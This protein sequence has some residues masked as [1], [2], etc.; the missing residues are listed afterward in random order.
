VNNAAAVGAMRDARRLWSPSGNGSKI[1]LPS[2]LDSRGAVYDAES[3][4]VA[5]IRRP[6]KNQP[7]PSNIR[8]TRIEA[9]VTQ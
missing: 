9:D 8:I 7:P 2:P 3:G 4:L 5:G 1:C 6:K